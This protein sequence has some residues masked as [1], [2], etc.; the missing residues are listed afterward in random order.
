MTVAEIVGLI[1]M[2]SMMG[3]SIRYGVPI[4]FKSS[5]FLFKL[6]LTGFVALVIVMSLA[7]LA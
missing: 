4:I 6:S 1:F 3:A 5:I 2:L 7:Q